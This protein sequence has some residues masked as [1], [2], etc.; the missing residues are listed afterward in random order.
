MLSNSAHAHGRASVSKD[1]R[2]RAIASLGLGL[3]PLLLPG[4]GT[5]TTSDEAMHDASD[6]GLVDNG[7]HSDRSHCGRLRQPAAE[8]RVHKV[9]SDTHRGCW[10][11]ELRPYTHTNT[12]A[13]TTISSFSLLPSRIA[14]VRLCATVCVAARRTAAVMASGAMAPPPRALFTYGTLR[15]DDDSGAP[16]GLQFLN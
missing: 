4:P 15:D 1:A 6:L 14:S 8:R 3:P 7:D 11:V 10:C 2:S 9:H 16:V 5:A 12:R 13:H